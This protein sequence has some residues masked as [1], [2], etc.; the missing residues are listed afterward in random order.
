MWWNR[1]SGDSTAEGSYFKN[2][3]SRCEQGWNI[4]CLSDRAETD[5]FLVMSGVEAGLQSASL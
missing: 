3:A 2:A 4:G 1:R 5:S